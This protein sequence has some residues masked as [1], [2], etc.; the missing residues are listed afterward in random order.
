MLV[1]PH[2]VFFGDLQLSRALDGITVSHRT[3]NSPP[4]H[5]PVHT[6]TDAHFALITSGGYVSSAT[7]EAHPHT[8]L[9]YNPP[10]T[11][12]RDH[13]VAYLLAVDRQQRDFVPAEERRTAA[14]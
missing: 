14:A 13:L 8:T 12:H 7:G 6:H 4:E 9:I 5:L 10:G 3:A 1:L 11:K 2:N